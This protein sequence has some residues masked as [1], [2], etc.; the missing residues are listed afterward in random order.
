M[1]VLLI[2]TLSVINNIYAFILYCLPVYLA[3]F[4]LDNSGHRLWLVFL[5]LLPALGITIQYQIQKRHV[6]FNQRLM[7]KFQEERER[8]SDLSMLDPL[9]GLYNRR[10]FQ[11]QFESMMA[12]GKGNHFILLLDIDR[13]KSYNDHYGHSMGDQTLMRVSAAIRDAV[14]AKD[15]VA[16]YGGEEF[17]VM[18]TD[19][20]SSQALQTAERIRQYV[21]DLNITHQFNHELDNNITISI[22]ITP[23]QG[24]DIEQALLLADQALYKAKNHGRNK[25]LPAET[26]ELQ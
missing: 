16:R 7:N 21:Y 8:L 13:F 1:S 23:L 18:L 3:A 5:T 6:E 20:Q 9:T 12:K 10:G 25:I 15:I 11:H 14:R 19:I 22:G 26:F 17:L 2:A 24:D 4:W